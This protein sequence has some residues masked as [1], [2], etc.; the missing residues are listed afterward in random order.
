MM[1]NI[2]TYGINLTPHPE[3]YQNDDEV[4]FDFMHKT[5]NFG[6]LLKAN[7]YKVAYMHGPLALFEGQMIFAHD[8]DITN[9]ESFAKE[10]PVK[11]EYLFFLYKKF[12]KKVSLAKLNREEVNKRRKELKI[13][14]TKKKKSVVSGNFSFDKPPQ[15]G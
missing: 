12:P 6:N 15:K 1:T 13:K 8:Y 10:F 9:L 2:E 14:P 3:K 11:D 7:G 4:T 5:W